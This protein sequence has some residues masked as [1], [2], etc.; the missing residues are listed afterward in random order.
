MILIQVIRITVY[1]KSGKTYA[2]LKGEQD[3]S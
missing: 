2:V 1:I 3:A